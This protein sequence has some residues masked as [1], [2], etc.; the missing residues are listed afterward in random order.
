[1]PSF[2][3]PDYAAHLEQLLLQNEALGRENDMF[4]SF[5]RKYDEKLASMEFEEPQKAKKG[6]KKKGVFV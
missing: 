3:D 2:A 6:A 1:M 5:L 4:H